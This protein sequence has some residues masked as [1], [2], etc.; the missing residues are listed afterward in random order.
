MGDVTQRELIGWGLA[1]AGLV[2]GVAAAAVQGGWFAALSAASG[3]LTS[4]SMTWGFLSRQPASSAPP[5]PPVK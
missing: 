4:M 3:G 5:V 1:M 2:C